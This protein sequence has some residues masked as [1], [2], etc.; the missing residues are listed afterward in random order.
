MS[1][2]ASAN[3]HI[4][5][6]LVGVGLHGLTIAEKILEDGYSLLAC[7]DPGEKAN[8][9]LG[10]HIQHPRAALI[11]VLAD[12]AAAIEEFGSQSDIAILTPAVDGPL[13]AQI[14][15]RY[16]AAGINVITIHQDFFG[17]GDWTEGL[18]RVARHTGTSFLATGVQDTWWV[19]LPNLIAASTTELRAIEFNSV[20][21]LDSLSAEV[22]TE[23]G[24]NLSAADF[25][26]HAKVILDYPAVMGLPIEECA[27]KLGLHIVKTA[28]EITPVTS[29]QPRMWTSGETTIAAGSTIGMKEVTRFDTAE[30]ITLTGSISARLLDDGEVSHD[31]LDIKGAPDIHLEFSPFPGEFITNAALVNRIH[32]VMNASP[33]VHF[34]ADLP[35]AQYRPSNATYE[36]DSK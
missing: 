35:P 25:K 15:E 9:Q 7:V 1:R 21:D 20:V 27:R 33:G 36:K 8:T 16:L 26:T 6:L 17:P 31:S 30:G 12:T 13:L 19:H 4:K 32:D 2:T 29:D 10:A 23:I 5:V 34:V 28:R 14:A 22:G 11:P 18:D 24:A 3:Q